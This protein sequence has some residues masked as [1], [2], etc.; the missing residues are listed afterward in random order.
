MIRV[1]GRHAPKP[2]DGR[3]KAARRHRERLA[4]I[5]DHVDPHGL[6]VSSFTTAAAQRLVTFWLMAED[7]DIA[8]QNGEDV[9]PGEYCG[10]HDRIR[11]L[12]VELGL[13][14]ALVELNANGKPVPQRASNGR[15]REPLDLEAYLATKDD[16]YG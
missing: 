14:Y 4:E 11:T 10:L 2:F 13:P 6:G 12:C 8:M 15:E 3:Y 7:R 1:M 9:S 5:M 16:P